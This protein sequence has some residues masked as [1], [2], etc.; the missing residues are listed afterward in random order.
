MIKVLTPA[1]KSIWQLC[2]IFILLTLSTL[3]CDDENESVTDKDIVEVS[4]ENA[5]LSTFVEA[6]SRFDALTSSFSGNQKFTIF[7]PNNV[8]FESFFQTIGVTSLANLSDEALLEVLKFHVVASASISSN[9][10]RNG[11]LLT[12]VGEKVLVNKANGITI[13]ATS[14]VVTPDIIASNG[15]VHII[16]KV[17]VPASITPIL[18]TI[19]APIYFGKATN[20]GFNTLLAAV[21]KGD[22]VVDLL[23][24]PSTVKTFFAPTNDAFLK[25]KIVVAT[26]SAS[27]LANVLKYHMLL[28]EVGSSDLP[29]T[30]FATP[31]PV[32]SLTTS[33]FYLSNN[34]SDNKSAT[35]SIFINGTSAVKDVDL[36]SGGSVFHSVD[37]VLIAPSKTLA[38]IITDSTKAK[39][40]QFTELLKALKITGLIDEATDATT[41]LTVF[42]PTDEAFKKLYE[43]LVV[44]NIND[45]PVGTLTDVLSLHILSGRVFSTD[46]PRR[47]Y[48]S[49]T[50][51]GED[52]IINAKDLKVK[53]PN[54]S[55]ANLKDV[56]THATNGVIHKIDKVL[57][58]LD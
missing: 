22:G 46:L 29:L 40:P 31:A 18:G 47:N 5:N 42:A 17:L 10:F 14:K 8:A 51:L 3:S 33:D 28:T 21:A 45:I 30:A 50:L 32:T 58:P 7:A 19:L 20:K 26:T 48:T 35:D 38:T 34:N 53:D 4:S 11:E 49:T 56:N 41:T 9:Q 36:Q 37:N 13:N 6:V 2:A 15:V 43:D 12:E 23:K 39:N 16:D 27:D 24:S 57:L 55:E 44:D 54:S 52:I 25:A 1:N